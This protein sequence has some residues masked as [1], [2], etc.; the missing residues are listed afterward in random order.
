MNW[1]KSKQFQTMPTFVDDAVWEYFKEI[2]LG[3]LKHSEGKLKKIIEFMRHYYIS[4]DLYLA[5]YYEF[6][7]K[8]LF[9][10]LLSFGFQNVTRIDPYKTG[11]LYISTEQ[12]RFIIIKKNSLRAYTTSLTATKNRGLTGPQ[13]FLQE[14]TDF[15]QQISINIR[16]LSTVDEHETDSQEQ[17]LAAFCRSIWSKV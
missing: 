4:D 6:K 5:S 10:D 14:V 7:V 9:P 12:C 11:V 16:V 2:N 15:V 1:D 3:D 13:I 17:T 8:I